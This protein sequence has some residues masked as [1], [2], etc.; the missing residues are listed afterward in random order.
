MSVENQD[1][2]TKLNNYNSENEWEGFEALSN[3]SD[4]EVKRFYDDSA[5][6]FQIL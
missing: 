5:I 4:S 1:S 6:L 3:S 2:A